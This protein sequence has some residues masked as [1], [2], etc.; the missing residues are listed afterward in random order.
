MKFGIGVRIA[1][2]RIPPAQGALWNVLAQVISVADMPSYGVTDETVIP[3][4]KV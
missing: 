1:A 2:I 3:S 4:N